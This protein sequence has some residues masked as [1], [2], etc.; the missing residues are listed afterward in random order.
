MGVGRH[1]RVLVGSEKNEDA[2]V[3]EIAGFLSRE[4]CRAI[5]GATEATGFELTNQRETRYAA[6]RRNGA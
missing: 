2:D 6:R 4:E 3:F 1:K 5:I